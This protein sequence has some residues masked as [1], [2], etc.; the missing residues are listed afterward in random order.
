MK[1]LFAPISFI[2]VLATGMMVY[3]FIGYCTEGVESMR[4]QSKQTGGVPVTISH[5]A[6]FHLDLN[7][8][9]RF[10]LALANIKNLFREIPAQQCDISVVANGN[11]VN[12]FK[13]NAVP[14]HG[15]TIEELHNLGVHFKM[16]RNA[17]A[18]NKISKEDLIDVCEIVPAGILEIIDLQ[19][20][21]FAYIKP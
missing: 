6:V 11:A 5:K 21:G 7:Q 10:T 15:K 17:L 18:N 19:R 3:P 13:K 20:M 16:C 1:K 14:G 8:E 9:D 4:P 2:F 12:L